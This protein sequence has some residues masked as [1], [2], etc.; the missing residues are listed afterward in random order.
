MWAVVE[1]D[2][3]DNSDSESEADHADDGLVAS[4]LCIDLRRDVE[5]AEP[6]VNTFA[7]DPAGGKDHWS[8]LPCSWIAW[9][10]VPKIQIRL[11]V[12]SNEDKRGDLNGFE[13]D[14]RGETLGAGGNR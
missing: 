3:W 1:N 5:G 12:R 11:F 4:H 2:L 7:G 10:Q 14:T 13:D 6:G 8:L 9:P